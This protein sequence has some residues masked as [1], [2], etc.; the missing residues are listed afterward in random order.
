MGDYPVQAYQ[1][2]ENPEN[3]C[4]AAVTMDVTRPAAIVADRADR[5]SKLR[6][7]SVIPS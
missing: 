7:V 2:K 6:T 4:L 5:K 3:L 1:M